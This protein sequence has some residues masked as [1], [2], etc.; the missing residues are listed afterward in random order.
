MDNEESTLDLPAIPDCDSWPPLLP[1]GS[2]RVLNPEWRTETVVAL[3]R[4]IDEEQAFE[5]LPILA[6]ALEEAGCDDVPTLLHCRGC[7]DHDEDCWVIAFALGRSQDITISFP[8]ITLSTLP[9][10]SLPAYPALPQDQ[11]EPTSTVREGFRRNWRI[12][13]V[14]L[15][16]VLSLNFFR[17]D[18]SRSRPSRSESDSLKQHDPFHEEM[19]L[20]ELPPSLKASMSSNWQFPTAKV[21][22]PGEAT[23]LTS[24]SKP[25]TP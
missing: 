8:V 5:R 12:L 18:D 14:V 3:A 7:N 6:D 15:L 13:I 21:Q 22:L 1:D 24:T 19:S 16:I 20:P 4:G 25:T 17:K 9:A 10:T 23:S 11:P 2:H